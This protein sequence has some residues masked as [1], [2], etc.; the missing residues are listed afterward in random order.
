M[1]NPV[2][3]HVGGATLALGIDASVGTVTSPEAEH[4]AVKLP[5]LTLAIAE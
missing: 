1:G 2:V 5:V 3:V 4:S